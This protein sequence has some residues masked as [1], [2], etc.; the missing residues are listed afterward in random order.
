MSKKG[1]N[2]LFIILLTVSILILLTG[3]VMLVNHLSVYGINR[4]TLMVSGYSGH[5]IILVGIISLIV[6]YYSASPFSKVRNIDFNLF[7]KKRN[8][9]KKK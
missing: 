2:H 5:L 4:R 3:G 6:T 9:D 8:G 7:K 1:S